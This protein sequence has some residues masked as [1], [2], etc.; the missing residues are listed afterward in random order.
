MDPLAC[1]NRLLDAFRESDYE[2]CASACDDL[3]HWLLRGSFRPKEL[4]GIVTSAALLT[5]ATFC[6]FQISA[7]ELQEYD[8]Q[9]FGGDY[10]YSPDDRFILADPVEASKAVLV[11]GK[12]RK[13]SQ[14]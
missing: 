8:E 9:M 13:D 14:K 3:R 1:W 12:S 2:E 11:F 6:R 5:L 10:A 7:D 4:P